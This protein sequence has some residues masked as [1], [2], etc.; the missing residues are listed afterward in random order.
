MRYLTIFI[1]FILVEISSAQN[2]WICQ[3]P[4]PTGNPLASTYFISADTGLIVGEYGTMLKTLDGGI[5]WYKINHEYHLDFSSVFF[6]NSNIGW[7]TARKFILKT[8]DGGETWI[9][10]VWN[11]WQS[12]NSIY[13]VNENVGY[14]VA[15]NYFIYTFDGGLN[16]NTIYDYKDNY[17]V[18]F[19]NSDTGWVS[20]E[21]D[22]VISGMPSTVGSII[23]TNDR[24]QTWYEQFSTNNYRKINDIYFINDI[25]GCAVGDYGLIINTIDGGVNWTE[26]NSGVQDDLISVKFTSSQLGWI[27]GENGCVLYTLDG[28]LTWIQQNLNITYCLN[29][30]FFVDYNIGWI[31]GDK[32]II[33]NT[34]DSGTT[35]LTQTRGTHDTLNS[36]DFIDENVGWTVGNNGTILQTI[37][38]GDNWLYNNANTLIDLNDII[39]INSQ[40][41][42]IVGDNGLIV[43]TSNGGQIWN[44][45]NS[46]TSLNLYKIFFLNDNIG[47]IT[48]GSGFGE[49]IILQTFDSGLTWTISYNSDLTLYSIKFVDHLLG[50]AVGGKPLD[51]WHTQGIM[52]KT[53]DGG[54][55]WI[56]INSSEITS[57][58]YD[59]YF[60]NNDTGWAVGEEGLILNTSDGGNSWIRQFHFGTFRYFNKVFFQNLNYGTV[61]G[62]GIRYSDDGG[63]SWENDFP[64]AGE[65]FYDVEF[66]NEKAWVIGGNGTILYTPNYNLT[67]I[68]KDYAIDF[69]YPDNISLYQ[70]YPNPFNSST[71]ISFSIEKSG[72]VTLKIYD[73][74][75]KN[76]ETLINRFK[77]PGA[78]NINFNANEL[79]SGIYFYK[80][81]VE[82]E[83]SETKKMILIR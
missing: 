28:G 5:N 36:I 29:D 44:T 83:Y 61:V 22:T 34:I 37:N 26:L 32:G 51:N 4:K 52:L 67:G 79:P 76:I 18:F 20:T 14:A 33:L 31:I 59:I 48:G 40:N 11:G 66:I 74:L 81:Q 39:F 7:A 60:I 49:G 15:Q 1:L 63:Y 70:N 72:F 64:G 45:H 13:F 38:G 43:S 68:N 6:I 55:N 65:P 2:H 12:I 78:Y 21:K 46:P 82:N 50:W 80:V 58:L 24:G 41:G 42:W 73:V 27:V 56:E 23:K 19:I 47:C 54:N 16:W 57:T 69:N 77:K 9:E 75:G 35:W 17:D 10:Q 71:K 53:V 3:N 30:I 8:E 25:I 62:F